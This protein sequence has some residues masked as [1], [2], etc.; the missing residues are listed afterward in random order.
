MTTEDGN[1]QEVLPLGNNEVAKCLEDVAELLEAQAAN[2]F[3]VQAYRSAAEVIRKLERPACEIL[4]QEGLAGL[5]RLPG[6][7]VSLAR[8]IEELAHTGQL[9]LLERLRGEGETERLLETVPSIGP[10]FAH[11]IHEQLGIE[12]LQELEIAAYDGRLSKLPGMGVKRIRAI[13]ESLA[14]RFRRRPRI[15]ESAPQPQTSNLPPVAE[16]LD[17]DDEYRRKAETSRLPRI[18]PRRF[19]P[20][21]ANWLPILHTHRGERHYTALFSNTAR[22]HELGTVHDWVVIY[23]DDHYGDGQWT[24]ITSGFGP[25]KGRR[26]VR[27]RERECA[28]HYAMVVEPHHEQKILFSAP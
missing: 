8:S 17:V 7:G 23:R 21:G 18:A 4:K 25:L 19:N 13:R 2:Q 20:T 28:D 10:K 3:R 26:I 6:I 27:G 1:R 9:A 11:L 16:L 22:A 5:T 15:P 24:V 14:G 12:N